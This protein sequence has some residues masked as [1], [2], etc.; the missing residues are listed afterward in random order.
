[1]F[2]RPVKLPKPV[3]N[4]KPQPAGAGVLTIEPA[5][6]GKTVWTSINALEFTATK[7]FDPEQ[8]YK[9]TVAGVS[10]TDDVALEKPWTAKFTAEPRIEIAGKVIDYLPTVGEPAWSRCSRTRAAASRTA[11]DPR[12]LRSAGDR[13]SRRPS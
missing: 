8:T 11:R 2:N 13:R 12:R 7:P 9:L 10:T 1:V 5:V 3:K 6:A 4:N